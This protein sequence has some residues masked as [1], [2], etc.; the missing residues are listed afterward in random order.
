MNDEHVA[1]HW[2]ANAPAWTAL[3]RAGY[4]VWRDVVNTP[5]FLELLPPVNGLAGIDI[6]CGEGANTRTIARLGARMTGI[7]IS[8]TFIAHATAE[9]Q[10]EPLGIT[11]LVAPAQGLPFRDG[12]FAFAT[13]FMS[14]MDVADYRGALQEAQRVIAPGG[15]LQFSIIH[16]CFFP[17]DRRLTVDADGRVTAVTLSRY[18]ERA[19]FIE[20]WT[21]TAAPE[22]ERSRYPP[23][24]VPV[25]HRTLADCLNGVLDTGFRIERIA[26]PSPSDE[27]IREHPRLQTMRVTATLLHVLCRKP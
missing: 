3:A 18:F 10:R 6:G 23:F 16:P 12:Q 8:P 27:Q 20:E 25:F 7:D 17:P 15:F 9:E 22:A 11:Y 19:E 24:R 5:A 2:E 14:L 13:A 1:A 21:F 26:E 4:D